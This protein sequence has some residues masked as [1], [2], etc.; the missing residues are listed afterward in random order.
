MNFKK[1]YDKL[2][3]YTPIP[4]PQSKKD[5]DPFHPPTTNSDKRPQQGLGFWCARALTH[6]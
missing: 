3:I 6:H 2:E 5:H 4:G 1:R